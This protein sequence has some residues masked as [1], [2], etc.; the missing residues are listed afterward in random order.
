MEEKRDMVVGFSFNE[1]YSNVLLILKNRPDWQKGNYNGIGGHIEKNESPLQAMERE[2]LE[3]A[4][5]GPLDAIEPWKLIA[6]GQCR[7]DVKLHIFANR[8]NID[9]AISTTDEMVSIQSVSYLPHNII[10]NLTWLIPLAIDMLKNGLP[11]TPI[12]FSYI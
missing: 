7:M 4:G 5:V 3:E 10:S 1:D 12:H 9:G 6:V 2:M 8:A 11:P